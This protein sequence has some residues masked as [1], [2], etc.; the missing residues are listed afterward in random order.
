[1]RIGVLGTGTIATAVV[2]GIADDGHNITVSE[3]SAVNATSLAAAYATVSIADNQAVLDHC[4][5]VFLGLMAETAGHLLPDLTFRSDHRVIS[6]MAGA[7]LAQVTELVAP[8][9]AE[10]VMMPFPGIAHGGSPILAQGNTDLIEMIFGGKNSVFPVRDDKEMSAYLSAQA[11][12]SPVARMVET[13]STWLGDRA[14]APE[15]GEAFMRALVSSSLEQSN[16]SDLI[17]ALNTPGGYNQR[18]RVHMEDSG[19]RAALTKG[20]DDL[21]RGS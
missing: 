2:H 20:L 7:S 19:Q 6:F 12:L 18:L 3:R 1:M 11:V 8:A 14:T 21:E 4:D 9:T 17:E 13:A 16:C 10:A 15:Q 5:V